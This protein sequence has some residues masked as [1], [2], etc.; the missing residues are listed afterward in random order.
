MADHLVAGGRGWSRV[1]VVAQAQDLRV[2]Y[3][4]QAGGLHQEGPDPVGQVPAFGSRPAPGL[5]GEHG[6][7]REPRLSASRALHGDEPCRSLWWHVRGHGHAE[8]ARQ[9]LHDQGFGVHRSPPSCVERFQ[10]RVVPG[11]DAAC[12]PGG[13]HDAC[14]GAGA[15][16]HGVRADVI[17]GEPGVGRDG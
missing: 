5:H 12:F 6:T 14:T 16:V 9:V 2:G 4:R 7:G 8:P 11:V 17:G 1:R 3:L 10:D 15:S 13:G